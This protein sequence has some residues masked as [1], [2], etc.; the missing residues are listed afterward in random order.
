MANPARFDLV[1]VGGGI[2][3]A[4]IARDA[5]GRG[6]SVLLCEQGDLA[7][8]TSS[9]STKLIHGGLRYLE[10]YEFRMVAKA[11]AE[12][13]VLLRAAPHII[14]PLRFVLPH[15]R[16]LR[17]A[18]MIRAGLFLYD[19]LGGGRRALAG[20]RSI[21]LAGHP[22]GS[23]LKDGFRKGFVY[24]DAW[25]QDARLV[26]LNA[27][28]AAQRGARILT[29]TRCQ[30]ARREAEGW[31]VKLQEANG[32]SFEVKARGLVNATG[33]W[34]ASFVDD[35]A[36]LHRGYALRLDKG[37]H[38]V[39]PKLFGH[40]FAY[41]FQQPDG[42]I[43][44][45]IPFERDYT[46]IGTTESEYEADPAE[47]R[48]DPG[49]ME[50]LCT[51][52]NRYFKRQIT[53]ED[54]IWSYSGV[55]PLLNGNEDNASEVSRDYEIKLD[56][57]G[58]PLLNVFGGKLTTFRRLAEDAVNQLSPAL[59]TKAGAW[60]TNG[61]PLP[62]GERRPEAVLDELRA[63]KPWLGAQLAQRLVYTYGARTGAVLGDASQI[64]DLGAHFGAGLYRAE[65]D[66]LC[67]NEWA[68]T[69]AD[70][71][72]RRSKLGLKLKADAVQRLDNYLSSGGAD[73]EQ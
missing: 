6:L 32:R 69:T 5:A 3:G 63:R 2:N 68:R 73:Y 71:I 29:R 19:H 16:H 26:V 13:E 22:S 39:V 61:P 25:A 10:Q 57:A 18:W 35:V 51:A 50:Y 30:C 40:G 34:A 45:A 44:F 28:D 17:P 33:P 54:I 12:R 23:A 70:V 38:I 42:R 53:T 4:G 60:T 58:P 20:S 46:L 67:A 24:S 72:W 8:Q 31:R 11:L 62:G 66:Y 1:V 37:S 65:V 47:A 52:A 64:E 7:G 49:E 27:L 55:R 41:I 15:Q 56:T 43:V 21:R 14:H 36:H 9:A 59:G 48:I